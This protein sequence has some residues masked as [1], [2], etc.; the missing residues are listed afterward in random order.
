MSNTKSETTNKNESSPLQ[1]ILLFANQVL[2]KFFQPI[3]FMNQY[4]DTYY[5]TTASG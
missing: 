1:A 3:Y 5:Y 4:G 2:G